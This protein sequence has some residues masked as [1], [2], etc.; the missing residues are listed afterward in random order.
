LVACRARVFFVSS[1]SFTFSNFGRV[2]LLFFS[3]NHSFEMK[4]SFVVSLAL[5]ALAL[6][7]PAP[8]KGRKSGGN[9]AAGNN[10]AAAAAGAASTAAAAN[11]AGKGAAAGAAGAAASSAKNVDA[12]TSARAAAVGTSGAELQV[13]AGAVVLEGN[14]FNTNNPPQSDPTFDATT[15][16]GDLGPFTPV[17]Q[18]SPAATGAPTSVDAATGAA[19]LAAVSNWMT[20]TTMVSNFLNNGGIMDAAAF[21]MAAHVAYAAEV[22]ELTHKAVLDSVIGNDP[23]VSIAN[24]TLTNGVF[25]SVVNNL[26][27]M[28]VQ[29]ASKNN[30]IDAI[31]QV[32]CTQVLPSIDTYMAVVNRIVP[33]SVLK[34]SIRPDACGAILAQNANN[35]AAFPNV[36]NTP[37]GDPLASVSGAANN[38]A[39][40][41]AAGVVQSAAATGAVNAAT[42]AAK[43]VP[44]A[45]AKQQA[46]KKTTSSKKN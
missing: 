3:T 38:A 10:N 1:F 29:G 9:A 42:Q 11:N 8:N 12:D 20:D 27:I 17:R 7:A 23:Q 32:R 19:L 21:P 45:A 31:N 46:A 34:T 25:Q 39:A 28:S 26:Q 14:T 44:T 43:V 22:D 5:S 2:H 4:Y 36:P 33:N 15:S 41:A 37:G 24:L 6:A 40:M 18:P 35:E 13:L 16:S 30:L